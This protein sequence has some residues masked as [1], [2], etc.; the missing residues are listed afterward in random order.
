MDSQHFDYEA[1]EPLPDAEHKRS[2]IHTRALNNVLGCEA[3]SLAFIAEQI[4]EQQYKIAG[5][6]TGALV[7]F[8]GIARRS[9]R[10]GP[11]N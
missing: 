8:N 6:L 1:P 4:S 7:T 5:V 3:L 10:R 9:L 11:E 2:C